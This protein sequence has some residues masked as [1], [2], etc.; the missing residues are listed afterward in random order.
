MFWMN[1]EF[2]KKREA[3]L[4]EQKSTNNSMEEAL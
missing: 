4:Q 1:G 3:F 2:L